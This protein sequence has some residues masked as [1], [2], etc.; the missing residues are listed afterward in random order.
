[1][2]DDKVPQISEN[3]EELLQ[4]VIEPLSKLKVDA[5]SDGK[6]FHQ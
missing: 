6:Q 3:L 4:H 5:D 1:M 2:E